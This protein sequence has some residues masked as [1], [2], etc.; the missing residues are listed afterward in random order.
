MLSVKHYFIQA[1]QDLV[2]ND[3]LFL[4]LVLFAVLV[5]STATNVPEMTDEV[6]V[7][8]KSNFLCDIADGPYRGFKKVARCVDARKDYVLDRGHAEKP[9]EN[10][11]EMALGNTG[12]PNKLFDLDLLGVITMNIVDHVS[13]V[14]VPS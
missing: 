4:V 11:L 10:T 1:W 6:T 12:D 2:L 13:K 9:L 7:I 5:G 14:F 8:V 3:R